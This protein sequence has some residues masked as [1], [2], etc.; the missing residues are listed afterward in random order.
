[1]DLVSVIQY[2]A[3]SV[4]SSTENG[5]SML[6]KLDELSVSDIV[7]ET[8]DLSYCECMGNF[9]E[10]IVE[11]VLTSFGLPYVART[12]RNESVDGTLDGY[13][14]EIKTTTTKK[15]AFRRRDADNVS[16]RETKLAYCKEAGLEPIVIAV[17]VLDEETVD[18][19]WR[20]GFGAWRYST[21]HSIL[22]F[23][24]LFPEAADKISVQLGMA[25]VGMKA[26]SDKSVIIQTVMP[27][28]VSD[29]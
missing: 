22:S 5:E 23:L 10:G 29:G 13:G 15:I 14:I 3:G 25:G 20:R 24:T 2:T 28:G 1:M 26:M 9:G 6:L 19:R 12:K 27:S 7:R 8:G 21:M 4:R 16:T 11:F 18:I 17:F